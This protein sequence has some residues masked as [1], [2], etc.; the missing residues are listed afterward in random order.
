M[1]DAA[2]GRDIAQGAQLIPSVRAKCWQAILKWRL[3]HGI[4]D[5]IGKALTIASCENADRK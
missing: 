5:D 4:K 2:I 3:L 1:I